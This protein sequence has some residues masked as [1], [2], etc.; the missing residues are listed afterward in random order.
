M[1]KG[2]KRYV[3]V[4][5]FLSLISYAECLLIFVNTRGVG[6]MIVLGKR[7]IRLAIVRNEV[8]FIC[9]SVIQ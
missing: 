1:L 5:K 8:L 4:P 9:I 2:L 7:D 6:T 3:T